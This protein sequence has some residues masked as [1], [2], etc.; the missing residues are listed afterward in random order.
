MA[1]LLR[2]V[3]PW[4]GPEAMSDAEAA[5]A[6]PRDVSD[7]EWK[8][9]RAKADAE[10]QKQYAKMQETAEWKRGV[11]DDGAPNDKLRC[12]I[13]N[14][15]G[16]LRV[17]AH[18]VPVTLPEDGKYTAKMLEMVHET[19]MPMFEFGESFGTF[20][21]E[22]DRVFVEGNFDLSVDTMEDGATGFF[23]EARM[24]TYVD[25]KKERMVRTRSDSGWHIFIEREKPTFVNELDQATGL[26]ASP[27]PE[28]FEVVE[29]T[30]GSA[31]TKGLSARLVASPDWKHHAGTATGVP[32]S[33]GEMVQTVARAG[34]NYIVDVAGEYIYTWSDV[35][36]FFR[37]NYNTFFGPDEV[38]D[39]GWMKDPIVRVG[40]G[41][42][43]LLL[44]VATV[45]IVVH[46]T[47]LKPRSL[48]NPQ[49]RNSGTTRRQTANA[50]ID[51][52]AA[53]AFREAYLSAQRFFG[54]V[55][56][57]L[58]INILKSL[59][60]TSNSSITG[61]IL[62]I[63][64]VVLANAVSDRSQ[65]SSVLNTILN[66]VTCQSTAAITETPGALTDATLSP[67]QAET[68][69][70]PST[71]P[72]PITP[73]PSAPPEA[74]PQP[75]LAPPA[76]P[77]PTTPPPAL[78]LPAPQ[79]LP[80]ADQE[81]LLM[82]DRDLG[83]LFK[84]TLKQTTTM[85]VNLPGLARL[86]DLF[87]ST[88]VYQELKDENDNQSD[89]ENIAT[90]LVDHYKAH[91]IDL[92]KILFRAIQQWN[93]QD[94]ETDPKGNKES[95]FRILLQ[96]I[97]DLR[98]LQTP[99]DEKLKVAMVYAGLVKSQMPPE[100]VAEVEKQTVEGTLTVKAFLE[101]LRKDTTEFPFSDLSVQSYFENVVRSNELALR[102]AKEL[103]VAIQ[104]QRLLGNEDLWF[105]HED[106]DQEYVSD[107]LRTL[108]RRVD[109]L[110]VSDDASR[111]LLAQY[112]GSVKGKVGP[113]NILE[114][115]ATFGKRG[116]IAYVRAKYI[117]D[118]A[119]GAAKN[120]DATS[121]ERN[122]VRKDRDENPAQW[123]AVSKPAENLPAGADGNTADALMMKQAAIQFQ[124]LILRMRSAF[125]RGDY[126]FAIDKLE[127]AAGRITREE[128]AAAAAAAPASA[129]AQAAR[130]PAAAPPSAPGVVRQDTVR[131][132]AAKA[133]AKQ[134]TGKRVNKSPPTA[135]TNTTT[136]ASLDTLLASHAA[137]TQRMRAYLEE[138]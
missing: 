69:Q 125:Q 1:S 79:R 24:W 114:W 9:L 33:A 91:P 136:A 64:S 53:N 84:E 98:R 138:L 137:A 34:V 63:G 128:G 56:T 107:I 68:A 117:S 29:E 61:S 12:L 93:V 23:S 133:A 58:T 2:K 14:G 130:A 119:P 92:S 39:E 123:V 111:T 15:D 108:R 18:G 120:P 60:Q 100:R 37:T 65:F 25:T 11:G 83:K 22:C 57:L 112:S 55:A 48:T 94:G 134:A 88:G 66:T 42:M 28:E 47:Y 5:D 4:P 75:P 96:V 35:T 106:R 40:L 82:D 116:L 26:W 71:P 103:Y 121:A 86:V 20:L 8:A 62:Q 30:A 110:R 129:P 45:M 115:E 89:L 44:A 54:N 131:K 46:G 77:T 105:L 59:A 101:D 49:G 104:K 122:G 97:H 73:P 90:M 7:E 87:Q 3:E 85:P 21:P 127:A 80:E 10:A 95:T 38:K 135:Q 67:Q 19:P 72:V 50:M 99:D 124:D 78:P 118:D 76:P 81:E 102:S 74:T 6:C 41:I 16:Q 126:Y 70:P 51:A 43:Y 13:P 31:S 109:V 52:T 17:I 132:M 36:A 113:N 27:E 32:V